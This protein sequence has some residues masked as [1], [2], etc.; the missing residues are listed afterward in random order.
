MVGKVAVVQ[1]GKRKVQRPFL[2][3]RVEEDEAFWLCSNVTV[4][5]LEE[6]A[7]ELMR[8]EET[9]FRYH[10][11]RNRNDFEEWIRD[12]IGD[13]ELA[14]DIARVKTRETLAKKIEIRVEEL[15]SRHDDDHKRMSYDNEKRRITR[16]NRRA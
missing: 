9:V 12:C 10:I 4:Q 8:V 6:M 16:I 1:K 14:R 7:Y 5:S 13:R 2:L 3:R 11:Q 15:K